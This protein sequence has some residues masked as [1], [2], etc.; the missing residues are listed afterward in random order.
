LRFENTSIKNPLYG[1]TGYSVVRTETADG[2][3]IIKGS[4]TK[5]LVEFRF[6]LSVGS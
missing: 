4:N 3:P 6:D 1:L 5:S 2:L